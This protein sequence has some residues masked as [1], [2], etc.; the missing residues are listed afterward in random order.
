MDTTTLLL[1]LFSVS[2]LPTHTPPPATV[3]YR[4][5]QE[6]WRSQSLSARSLRWRRESSW[7]LMRPR[8][9][10]AICI[11]PVPITHVRAPYTFDLRCAPSHTKLC[12]YE[13]RSAVFYLILFLSASSI[14]FAADHERNKEVVRKLAG[15]CSVRRSTTSH[16]RLN[17]E[18][19]RP[20]AVFCLRFVQMCVHFFRAE[21]G[22]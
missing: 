20:S 2:P 17:L 13:T 12:L 1:F 15:T 5:W 22:H 21:R 7:R 16:C 6:V 10:S 18:T 11:T 14:S 8:V 4:N 19:S 3:I 9:F